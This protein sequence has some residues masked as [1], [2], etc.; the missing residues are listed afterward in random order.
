MAFITAAFSP[1]FLALSLELTDIVLLSLQLRFE[2][3]AALCGHLP[4]LHP[5][6]L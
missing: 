6:V 1:G 2:G 5:S 4:I 3:T